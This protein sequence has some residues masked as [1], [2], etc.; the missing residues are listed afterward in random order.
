MDNLDRGNIQ[1]AVDREES[2]NI[3]CEDFLGIP[4]SKYRSRDVV[5]PSTGR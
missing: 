3:Q 5:E 1:R 2:V 4:V